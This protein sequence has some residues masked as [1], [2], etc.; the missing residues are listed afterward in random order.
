M[1]NE[2]KG[3]KFLIGVIDK[4]SVGTEGHLTVIEALGE[5]GGSIAQDFLIK[6]IAKYSVGTKGHRAVISAIGR[7]SRHH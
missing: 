2:N 6:L 3:V 5:A 4:Y 1:E 7:A